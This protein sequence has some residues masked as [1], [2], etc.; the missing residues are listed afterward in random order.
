MAQTFQINQLVD[1]QK[2]GFFNYKVLFWCFLAMF[3]DGYDIAAMAYAAPE[4]A[5]LWNLE[6]PE[7]G[8]VFSASLFGILLGAPLLGFMGDK[9]GRKIAIVSGCV[10]YG[11]STLAV[12][13]TSSL[14]QIFI[15]RFITGIGI[16]GLMPNTIS[17]NSELAPKRHRAKLI[18]LMFMGITLGTSTPGFVAAWL[19]PDYGWQIIFLIGGLAPLLIALCLQFVLPESVKYLATRTDRQPQLLKTI[20]IMRPDLK[21]SDDAIFVN[22]VEMATGITSSTRDLF[23]GGLAIITPLLWVCFSTALMA[24][25]FMNSWLPLVLGDLGMSE[26]DAALTTSWYHLGGALGGL[27]VSFLLDR[28][29]FMIIAVLFA[30]SVPAI[31]MVG[32]EGLSQSSLV[33]FVSFAGFAIVGAQFGNNAAAGLLYPTN[34]R[35]KG[36]GIALSIARFGA[37][38]GPLAGAVMI[39]MGLA[40]KTIFLVSSMP[41]LIGVASAVYLSKI[42]YQRFNG[43][44][45][46]DTPASSSS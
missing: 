7:F 45:L 18:V 20:R 34:C 5:R 27:A 28:Y 38:V 4:L 31:A 21:I 25:Y 12:V 3:A 14:D 10:I 42:C 8:L 24:N 37:I 33:F 13:W 22:P 2:L 19:V 35:S 23:K 43:F 6:M 32:A 46:D 40:W 29:G 16:G 44:Q 9:Y 17:L 36:V 15:L 30:L 41:M 1:G 11:V 39:S 26:V